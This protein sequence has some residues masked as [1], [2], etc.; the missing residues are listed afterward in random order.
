MGG[1]GASSSL[2]K[3]G[4][5]FKHESEAAL[6]A[7]NKLKNAGV[8]RYKSLPALEGM[9]KASRRTAQEVTNAFFEGRT[10]N[11]GKITKK[12]AA[13]ALKIVEHGDLANAKAFLN[14]NR[15]FDY[16]EYGNMNNVYNKAKNFLKGRK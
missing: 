12:T 9:S 10:P 16:K 8:D 5:G 3:K 11:V 2:S 6:Y 15:N 4:S 14:I 7:I 13:D 1:R